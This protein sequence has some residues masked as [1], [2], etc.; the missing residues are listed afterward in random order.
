MR[1]APKGGDC[2][3]LERERGPRFQPESPTH[4]STHNPV[5]SAP[6]PR[7]Q[8]QE[9]AGAVF[10]EDGTKLIR[11]T[12]QLVKAI[13]RVVD[14][15]KLR[16]GRDG[17]PP[18]HATDLYRVVA[19]LEDAAAARDPKFVRDLHNWTKRHL[20][21]L[22]NTAKASVQAELRDEV[23]VEIT[24]RWLGEQTGL[25]DAER[26]AIKFYDAEAIDLSE[27]DRIA[28]KKRKRAAMA[29]LRREVKEGATPRSRCRA[30]QRELQPGVSTSTWYHQN[31]AEQRV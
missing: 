16:Y 19:A 20:R 30:R 5:C 9:K 11:N 15:I 2:D 23:A 10:G 29:Q 13:G 22:S 7:N 4:F 14:L 12:G 31:P 6:R 18:E 8:E 21:S 17:C 27:A 1:L 25:L 3:T 28:K 26:D 24:Q